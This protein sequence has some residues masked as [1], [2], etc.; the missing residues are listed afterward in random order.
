MPIPIIDPPAAPAPTAI[1]MPP[2]RTAPIAP[3]AAIPPSLTAPND[4]NMGK[5]G[6]KTS[7]NLINDEA[8]FKVI[9]I[10][11][12]KPSL[13][14][15]LAIMSIN[16]SLTLVSFTSKASCAFAASKAKEL[17]PDIATFKAFC[18]IS[19]FVIIGITLPT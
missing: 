10:I 19:C 11:V 8:S 7:A 9:S 2:P 1:P 14:T 5:S 12:L 17:P 4:I 3:I 13:C 18:A 6:V 15:N 16:S